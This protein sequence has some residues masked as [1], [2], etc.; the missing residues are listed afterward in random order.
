M[1]EP[2]LAKWV[3]DRASLTEDEALELVR[4][5]EAD[6]A[7][8]RQARELL[9]V[10]DLLSRKLAADRADFPRQVA[11][12]LG[13]ASEGDRFPAATLQAIRTARRW[14]VRALEAAAALLLVGVLAFL[15][16]RRSAP[17]SIVA[18]AGAHGLQGD[19]FRYRDLQGAPTPRLDAAV[20][21]E[22]A[23]KTGPFPGW[24]DVF[25]VRWSGK[26]QP[27]VSGL[28]DFRTRND[29]GIRLWI[30]GKLVVDDWNARLVIVENR[31]S[32]RLEA[33][34]LYDV[35]VEYYN[36]GDRGVAQLYW[37]PPGMAEEIVPASCLRPR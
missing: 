25:S 24:R 33:G 13:A 19:Y 26:L 23:A 35:A 36:S 14:R 32:V 31:A 6:P 7:L 10:D 22:W 37:T 16:L 20:D 34:A 5:L 27:P 12:R 21:F 18:G 15:L 29:D 3:D 2:L 11:Q 4:L 9:V 8:A 17:E 1:N 30:G 28:Y